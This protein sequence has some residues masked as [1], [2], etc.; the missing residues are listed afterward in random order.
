MDS[1]TIVV[2]CLVVVV[3]LAIVLSAVLKF[4]THRAI[5]VTGGKP[6]SNKDLVVDTLNLTHLLHK[7][8]CI[9]NDSDKVSTCLIVD[10]IEYSTPIIKQKYEGDII[11][12]I[13]DKDSINLDERTKAIYFSLAK[14][15]RVSIH[16]AEKLNYDNVREDWQLPKP[17]GKHHQD[18]GRDDFYMGYLANKNK[19]RILTADK[20]R[21]FQELK[22]H[23]DPFSVTI[24][25]YWREIPTKNWINPGAAEFKRMRSPARLSPTK[26][27]AGPKIC[28][29]LT[30]LC[31]ENKR[32]QKST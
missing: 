5:V 24:M 7:H 6:V 30:S 4:I 1:S 22:K 11:F 21:D 3:V 32:S 19:C 25:E 13:K 8:K 9:R 27:F 15:L 18:I 23:V 14:R 17:E 20:M 12:V 16:V 26:L 2:L 31:K 10:A 28:N 29:E